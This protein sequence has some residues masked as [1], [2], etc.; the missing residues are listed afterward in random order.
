MGNIRPERNVGRRK[1]IGSHLGQITSTLGVNMI[2]GHEISLPAHLEFDLIHR[3]G[4]VCVA[5]CAIEG[6][7]RS[8]SSNYIRSEG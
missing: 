1:G 4:G 8:R 7:V 6:K 2:G 3:Y 5:T